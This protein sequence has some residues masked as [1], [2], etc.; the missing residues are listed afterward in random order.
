MQG[1]SLPVLLTVL[2]V[3]LKLTNVIAWSWWWVV[4]PLLI[5]AGISIAIFLVFLA[6]VIFFSR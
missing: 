2:F 1:F 6:G 4:S 3:A 5:S